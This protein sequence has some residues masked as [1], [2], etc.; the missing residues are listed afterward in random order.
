M[1]N[2]NKRL[3]RKK[4]ITTKTKK[5]RYFT[6]NKE[7]LLY[8]RYCNSVCC[9]MGCTW[10]FCFFFFEQHFI[11]WNVTPSNTIS[12]LFMT[13][14]Y[15]LFWSLYLFSFFWWPCTID[16]DRKKISS[17]VYVQ[18]VLIL[19]TRYFII[20][21]PFTVK[22]SSNIKREGNFIYSYF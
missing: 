16:F 14:K 12:S 21:A 2:W 13:C 20:R 15:R 1:W 8:T 9:T 7:G 17:I 19:F 6:L 3:N 22:P 11:V 18:S 4:I 10:H 5:K